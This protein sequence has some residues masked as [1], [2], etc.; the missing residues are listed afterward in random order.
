MGVLLQR[1]G[2]EQKSPEVLST[3]GILPSQPQFAHDNV[4]EAIIAPHKD[5]RAGFLERISTPDVRSSPDDNSTQ[6]KMTK[7]LAYPSGRGAPTAAASYSSAKGTYYDFDQGREVGAQKIST[8]GVSSPRPVT[9]SKG[10]DFF[11]FD[12]ADQAGGLTKDL[13]IQRQVPLRSLQRNLKHLLIHSQI[14]ALRM[15][16]IVHCEKHQRLR[17]IQGQQRVLRHL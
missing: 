9:V 14:L 7:N 8:G 15:M 4:S 13:S 11:D 12:K 16:L 17:T 10:Q 1:Y 6:D 5:D 2:F 3:R